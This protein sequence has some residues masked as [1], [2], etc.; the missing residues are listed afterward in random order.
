MRTNFNIFTAIVLL[1]LAGSVS[2]IPLN[3]ASIRIHDWKDMGCHMSP[4]AA[5]A[6]ASGA[7]NAGGNQM[8]C[9]AC[10]SASGLPRWWI[11]EPYENLWIVDEP[12]GYLTSSGQKMAFRFIYKQ[13]YQVP[14]P[15][16]VPNLYTTTPDRIGKGNPLANPYFN[17]M[18]TYGMTNASWS[19]N[20]MANILVWDRAWETTNITGRISRAVFSGSYEALV[21]RPE[22]GVQYFNTL[23]PS[24]AVS[25]SLSQVQLLPLSTYPQ[26]AF[27]PSH[28]TYSNYWGDA[29]MGFKL[30]YPDG[31]QDVFGFTFFQNDPTNTANSTGYAF[32]TQKIDPQGRVTKI[33]YQSG[34]SPG[35]GLGETYYTALR[36]HY[37]VDSDNRTNTFQYGNI[38]L[39]QP[40]WEVSEIDDP[41]GRKAQFSW[42]G[43]FLSSISDAMTNTSYFYYV[44]TN[45]SGWM[46]SMDTPYGTTT[47]NYY[48]NP[49]TNNAYYFYERATYVQEPQ[50]AQQLFYYANQ[51]NACVT[52]AIP[53]SVSGIT[54]FDAGTNGSAYPTLD[55]RNSVH[56][57]R[58]QFSVLSSNVNFYL[59]S[60]WYFSVSNA[61]YNLSA[62]DMKKGQLK[63]WL[64]GSD[65][66]SLSES[67]SSDRA[68]SPDFAGANEGPRIWFDYAGKTS[69]QPQEEGTSAQVNC[70]GTLL[71]DGSS[72]YRRYSYLNSIP[73]YQGFL[74]NSA[75]SYSSA[76]GVAEL[77]N[78]FVYSNLDLTTISNSLGQSTI[79]AYNTNHQV[80]FITNALKQ[81]TSLGYG[82]NH[83]LTSISL[84]S[85]ESASLGLNSSYQ[86]QSINVQPQ[87]RIIGI[88][89]YSA[90]MPSVVHATGTGLP[91]LWFTNTWDGLNRLVNT[92]FTNG[93]SISN[94]YTILDLSGQK[95]RLNNWTWFGF[96]G[97]EHLIY[98]ADPRGN[99]NYFSWCGCGALEGITDP[100]SNSTSFFYNNQQLLTNILYADGSWI[101]RS[102]DNVGRLTASADGA[103]R[104]LNFGYNN[105]GLVTS[106]SNAF[107]SVL[108]TV[109][110]GLNRPITI[111]DANGV[112]IT[113]QF[114]LLNRLT[115]RTWQD[116]IGET[117]GY[118]AKGLIAYTNRDGKYT[119]FTLDPRIRG[120]TNAN[121]EVTAFAYN[122]LD[123]LTDLW[124][125]R[126]DHTT[127]NYNQY[128]WLT[129]KLDA[130]GRE[131]VRY[132]QNPN[133]QV[134]NR[135]TPQFGNTGYA[136][137]PAGNLTNITYSGAGASTPSVAL[138]YDPLN[139]LT[140]MVDGAG[141][142]TFN[143]TAASQ[144]HT[145]LGPWTSDGVTNSY[146][147]QLRTAL[148]LAQP[149]GGAWS[150]TYGYDSAWRLT[151]LASPAGSFG[152]GYGSSPA[153]LLRTLALP[154]GA[155]E[156]NHFDS[157]SRMDFTALMDHWGHILDGYGYTPDPLG[158]RTNISRYLGM[159]TNNVAVGYD[160]IGQI[161]AWSGSE[162]NAGARV[163]RQNEQLAWVYDQAGNPLYRTN[164]ALLQNFITDPANELTNVTRT[165]N[166]TVSGATPAPATSVTVNG[167]P[168]LLYGDMT[169]AVT[170]FVLTNGLN[171]YTVIAHN[172]Y[173]TNQTNV[174]AATL[175]STVR[176][177]WDLNGNLTNDGTRLFMY[178]AENR[179]VTN[180]VAYAWKS[181]FVYDGLGR[182]RIE[183]DYGW[184]GSSWGSPTNELHFI[185]DGWLLMQIRDGNNNVLVTYTRGLD[186][187][188]SIAGAAGI[189]G[190]LARSDT[191]GP[192][193]YH[194]DGAGNVAAL[195][196]YS[197]LVRARY[198]YNPFGRL[199]AE[200][201][202]MAPVNEMQFSSMPV[203]RLSGMPHFFAREYVPDWQGWLQRDPLGEAGGI[204]LY[205]F[206]GNNPLTAVD[207]F[208]FGGE[209]DA[210]SLIGRLLAGPILALEN[211]I[212][213][214]YHLISDEPPRPDLPDPL[215]LSKP[216]PPIPVQ[217]I[218]L[219]EPSTAQLML[220]GLGGLWGEEF[221]LLK[222]K[223]PAENAPLANIL[224]GHSS[225]QGFTGVYDASSGNVLLAPSTRDA[226]IPA[227][228]VARAGGHAD[229]SAT[230]GGDAANH[231]G[232]AVILQEDGTLNITWRSGTLNPPPNYVV[233]PNL[234]P[235]IINEVQSATG[236]TI[237]Q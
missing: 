35:Q 123:E 74:S 118:S 169:F 208:G 13:R 196:D 114:D 81:V 97:L 216:M 149:S 190:L 91:D 79:F 205:R 139:R 77:T 177:Q 204:N 49:D 227:G 192:T 213:N 88:S 166:L 11:D 39:Q 83:S 53:P 174:V 57:D 144:L 157:L 137:D 150:Q 173:G 98:A 125:G 145:E 119:L 163:M 228:W 37:V 102:F 8:Y 155:S 206:V 6:P 85:G 181:E 154:N 42:P 56:W 93:I 121:N 30:L 183:R 226:Q 207:P 32:L 232:F 38:G 178:D 84:P 54:D 209:A 210:N 101:T 52:S 233:P 237:N 130:L 122:A 230:L 219:S 193:F 126:T 146:V 104:T 82:A 50:G 185:Y 229:V 211:S 153:S 5:G 151:S 18:R 188:G 109:Y 117:Y 220:L 73:P 106:V 147:Q 202:P 128:G 19:H 16:E 168:A 231:S 105:Q 62:A 132:T 69:G 191:N 215:D 94:V 31:S 133:G 59:T 197:Q 3:S 111:T 48:Q 135:L 17:F 142:H 164:A 51:N 156:T 99:T 61:V 160:K 7:N 71:P 96:D 24:N 70:M 107:G 21:F 217:S 212:A 67:I 115:A 63:H 184:S 76:G 201:G 225:G 165:G 28:D 199:I 148:A 58:P 112:T 235:T 86:V 223:C 36:V 172:T 162:T 158:L 140:S 34:T 92:A 131:I 95:D 170:N 12:L 27:P 198:L 20:Y 116:N 43:G 1:G 75:I 80:S 65:G 180:Y 134:T 89:N 124:D 218:D 138:I 236:R 129:N 136:F 2:A 113:N 100:L 45:N 10:Q 175:P 186:L 171:T 203:N 9:S 47:F 141:S 40:V 64:L 187:S 159:T 66:A 87:N 110:D 189:G 127:W 72:Q 29:G 4:G 176:L 68:P 23:F 41:Y 224:E 46:S 14:G 234:R 120:I 26:I 182:R 167:Q 161:T 221:S 44:N 60:Y 143:Y 108:Q 179:L 78:F 22:G 194:A 214:L 55:Y 222:P 152:H 15:D 33:A 25:D 90:G 195:M 103:G 200:W